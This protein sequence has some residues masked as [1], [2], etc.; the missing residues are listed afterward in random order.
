MMVEYTQKI[1][2]KEVSIMLSVQSFCLKDALG[3]D[4]PGTI[5]RLHEIGY[6]SFE[7]LLVFDEKQG[8]KPAN[9]FSFE[10]LAQLKPIL[11]SYGMAIPTA[12][13]G[14]GYGN[15]FMPTPKIISSMRRAHEEYGI[16]RF[17]VGG[18]FTTARGARKWAK[19]CSDVAEAIHPFG[20]TIVYHNHDVEFKQ[21]L[22]GGRTLTAM[23]YF[24][25]LVSPLVMLQPDIGWV[26][27]AVDEVEYVKQNAD[28]IVS[29]HLK[30][31][32]DGSNAYTAKN[33]PT[34]MFTPIGEGRVHTKEVLALMSSL[35]HAEGRLVVDQDRST[36]DIM[37]DIARG[38]QNIQAMLAEL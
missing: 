14:I 18:M 12:H 27:N 3:A 15:F 1:A 6:D 33:M 24:M 29:I 7:P 25:E 11:D 20:C 22:V 16:S 35:P 10:R 36:G 17:V 13:A 38:Y 32:K 31:L 8:K 5:R 9:L 26:S 2:K 21:I 19:V 28:R 4:L 34:E 30:D 23:D 37:D